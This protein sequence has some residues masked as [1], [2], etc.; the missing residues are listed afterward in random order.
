MHRRRSA[1]PLDL[2]GGELNLQRS[3]RSA[4]SPLPLAPSRW[5]ASSRSTRLGPEETADETAHGFPF[6]RIRESYRGLG[7]YGNDDVDGASHECLLQTIIHDDM[8]LLKPHRLPLTPPCAGLCLEYTGRR[9][10]TRAA[11][12]LRIEPPPG[13]LVPVPPDQQRAAAMAVRA[14]AGAVMHVAG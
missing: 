7:F 13:Q 1:G 5:I 10:A 6:T 9:G 8:R 4:P 2:V 14:A 11:S 12:S 3:P